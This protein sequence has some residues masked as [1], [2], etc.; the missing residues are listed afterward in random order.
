MEGGRGAAWP[1]RSGNGVSGELSA[2]AIN[3]QYV[4][5]T[6]LCNAEYR[7]RRSPDINSAVFW[8]GLK[9]N[10]LLQPRVFGAGN[11]EMRDPS[12]RRLPGPMEQAHAKDS[13]TFACL[14]GGI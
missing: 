10:R 13:C 5:P 12:S 11:K 9:Y 3:R 14:A 7:S 8:A 4:S 2:T 6:G 1:S